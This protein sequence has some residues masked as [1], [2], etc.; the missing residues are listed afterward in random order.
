MQNFFEDNFRKDRVSINFYLCLHKA[1][2]KNLF[3]KAENLKF[4]TEMLKQ[5]LRMID[6]NF[7]VYLDIVYQLKKDNKVAHKDINK[8]LSKYSKYNP[9]YRIFLFEDYSSIHKIDFKARWLLH[10]LKDSIK[11]IKFFKSN[12]LDIKE[13]I[14]KASEEMLFEENK[15]HKED[16]QKLIY[17]LLN[18]C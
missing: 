10:L 13:L 5:P 7:V 2:K 16:F 3:N 6:K 18:H 8:Y 9:F 12:K 17:L 15:N 4:I 1:I 11:L 14:S